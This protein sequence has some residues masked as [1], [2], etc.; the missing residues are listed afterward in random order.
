MTKDEVIEK[1]KAFPEVEEIW[2]CDFAHHGVTGICGDETP[3]AFIWQQ[4][5]NH[6]L[7]VV[8]R[9]SSNGLNAQESGTLLW[10]RR[11]TDVSE[12]AQ[13]P[14]EPLPDRIRRIWR[15]E[16]GPEVLSVERDVGCWVV[17]VKGVKSS[18]YESVLWIQD[19]DGDIAG[20]IRESIAAYAERFIRHHW[21]AGGGPEIGSIEFRRMPAR[22]TGSVFVHFKVGWRDVS[23]AVRTWNSWLMTHEA[24]N[25]AEQFGSSEAAHDLAGRSEADSKSWGEI[26]A[27]GL[28]RIENGNIVINAAV[29]TYS[30]EIMDSARESMRRACGHTIGTVEWAKDGYEPLT[31]PGTDTEQSLLEALMSGKKPHGETFDYWRMGEDPTAADAFVTRTAPCRCRVC[32]FCEAGPCTEH[33]AKHV[34]RVGCEEATAVARF[35]GHWAGRRQPDGRWSGYESDG[36]REMMEKGRVGK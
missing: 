9:T 10:S 29:A 5:H 25:T 19:P 11:D 16:G 27:G 35:A 34:L 30:E 18:F 22:E 12:L 28:V 17:S 7:S 20:M 8:C 6:G 21:A 24:E 36:D 1:L 14:K 33:R 2:S 26:A 32:Y 15:E 3:F 13:E 4:Q 31:T 23:N